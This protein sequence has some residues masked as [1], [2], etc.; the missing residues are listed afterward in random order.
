MSFLRKNFKRILPI[1]LAFILISTI[2]FVSSVTPS[3]SGTGAGLA[4]W[5]LNAYKE[6]WKYVYGGQTPG[7]VD[8]S[9][10]IYSY[11]GGERGG[12]AQLNTATESGDVSEGI[13]RIHGLGLYQPGHVGVYVGNGMAVDARDEESNMCYQSTATKSWTKWFKLAADQGNA[14]AQNNLGECYYYRLG[15]KQDIDE[16]IKWY[17]LSAEQNYAK[18]Q[19]NLGFCYHS[20]YGGSTDY[21]KAF[22]FY[23]LAANQG[24]AI[25]QY[26]LGFCYEYGV[27]TKKDKEKAS[28]WYKKS[29]EQ[30]DTNAQKKI[31]RNK[32]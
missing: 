12:T 27:G 8:C 25:A 7:E 4:E 11:C 31:K 21:Y 17:K 18:A 32:I 13:P 23:D 22:E 19:N 26:N 29:A 2:C 10:L 14:E 1:T 3:A 6:H 15:V 5:A 28:E 9:G 20:G 30:G 16:A 24:L